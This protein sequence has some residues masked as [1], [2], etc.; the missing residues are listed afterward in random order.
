MADLSAGGQETI[1]E[2]SVT[3]DDGKGSRLERGCQCRF[4]RGG[5]H[6]Q[7]LGDFVHRAFRGT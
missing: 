7:M 5:S 3:Q 6:A 2:R 4:P 1:L